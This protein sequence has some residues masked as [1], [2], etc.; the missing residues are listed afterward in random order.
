MNDPMNDFTSRMQELRDLSGVIGLL[1][2]DQETF[3]PRKGG[4]ARAHH[5]ATMQGILHERLTS[6]ALADAMAALESRR[7]LPPEQ[8]AMVRNVRFERD[9]AVKVPARLVK[10]LAER[11]S[12]SVEAWREARE[13]RDFSKFRPHLEVLVRLKREQADALGHQGERYD[14]LL[15]GFEPGM[16]VARLQPLLASLRQGLVPLVRA[17][18]ESKKRP[19]NPLSG[20]DFDVAKQWELSL[21]VLRD[22]GFDLEAGRQDKSTHPFTGGAGDPGDV[23]LTTRLF[24]DN[25]LSG[26]M[27]TIHEAG[28]GL[29]EQGF[30]SAHVRTYLA[31][32]PSFGVHE[33]QSRFWENLIGRSLPFWRHY[34]PLMQRHFPAELKGVKPEEIYAAVNRVEPSLIRVEADEVTYNLHILVRFE[35]ELALLKG[36]LAAA[37]LPQAWNARMKDYLGVTPSHDTEGAMQDIHW[38]WGEFGYFPTY[39]LGNLY[40]A[41]LLEKMQAD[42]PK[43]WSEVAAGN[44]RPALDWLRTKIHRQGFLYPA[45]ELMQK[46]TGQALSEKPFLAYLQA[47]YRPL[48]QLA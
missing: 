4:E 13:R 27:S 24:P 14:A 40:S 5:L 30:D 39:T 2:W 23:R 8:R 45:E 42:V 43:L 28:H 15:E 18:V 10:E 41:M 22:M 21:Q 16:R 11:Q 48:Y 31:Q 19:A 29:F 47:K 35:L 1:S 34:L 17:I 38:A 25:P 6:P 33:S 26:L 46:V 32:S 44:L 37:E 3:M 36:D 12:L 20:R 7:D 9:R